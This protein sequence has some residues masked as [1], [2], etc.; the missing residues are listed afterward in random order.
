MAEH[1]AINGVVLDAD[2]AWEL[3]DPTPLL[4]EGPARG[5]NRTIPGVAGEAHRTKLRGPL[6]D[7]LQVDVF[8]DK[9]HAGGAYA[10][11]RIGMRDNIEYLRTNLLTVNVGQV[12]LDYTFDDNS[13]RSG[14]CEVLS[15]TPAARSVV[16]DWTVCALEIVL[17]DGVLEAP[18]P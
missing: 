12:T 3:I 18:S 4:G 2:G 7:V 9:N 10:D 11:V 5:R 1:V 15:L 17:L 8:G 13:T 6:R 14:L 16:G